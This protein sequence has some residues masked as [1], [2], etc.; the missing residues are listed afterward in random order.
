M[1][2]NEFIQECE[3]I[4]L[5]VSKNILDKLKK[6]AE[7]LIE[8][9][10]KFNLTSIVELEKIYLKHFYD[11]ICISKIGN[12]QNTKLCDFGTGA[13]FP[14]MVLAIFFNYCEV[15]L[16]ESNNKKISFKSSKKRF[17]T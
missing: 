13:G 8:W 15:T 17:E 6:Y 10:K 11:S 16:I 2:E 12:I 3:K 7:L 14:G 5:K 9:N 4:N 1:T